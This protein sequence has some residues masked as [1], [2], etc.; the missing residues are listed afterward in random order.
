M[1]R[2]SWL[3]A[4]LSAAGIGGA[5]PPPQDPVIGMANP[6]SV[7]CAEQGGKLEIRTGPGGESGWC[8][9]PDGKVVE[10]WT[11]YRANH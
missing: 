9:L 1:E 4:L 8:H 7:Y 3:A 11:F 6:A 10:E 5:E 2:T